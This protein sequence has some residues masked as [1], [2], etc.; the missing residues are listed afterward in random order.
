MVT[1][2]YWVG[3]REHLPLIVGEPDGTP[4]TD[5]NVAIVR[6]GEPLTGAT[7]KPND[8]YVGKHGIWIDAIDDLT[9]GTYRVFARAGEGAPNER[10]LVECALVA[11]KD[12]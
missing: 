9:V 11:I 3:S 4:V 10:A 7:W 2:T 6:L 1:E 12:N 5:Y 8:L